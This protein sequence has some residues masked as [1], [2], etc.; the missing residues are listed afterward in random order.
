MAD[1][2]TH[3]FVNFDHSIQSN[4]DK[5][6]YRI[7]TFE[8]FLD[9]LG[10]ESLVL[11]KPRLWND[12][13]ENFLLKN[14]A[15]TD[16]GERVSFDNIRE[17]I[18]GQCWSYNEETEFM[19]RVYAPNGDGIK[20][21]TSVQKLYDEFIHPH[22]NDKQFMFFGNVIYEQWEKIKKEF[23]DMNVSELFNDTS[24]K[25]IVSTLLIKKAEYTQESELR[26]IAWS[27]WFRGDNNTIS[28]VSVNPNSLIEEIIIDPRVDKIRAQSW[29]KIIRVM[30][31][32]GLIS[33]SEL[34]SAPLLK[35]KM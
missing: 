4:L 35:L 15:W 25:T 2:N 23:E 14:V 33:H 16:E 26:I 8:R 6:I 5:S 29:E 20:I 19:W 13:S 31:Y 24:G 27:H 34:Y 9:L 12:P 1:I 7:F 18:Y 28:Y 3:C 30:G 10:N 11:V 32:R 21:K 17:R 22:H